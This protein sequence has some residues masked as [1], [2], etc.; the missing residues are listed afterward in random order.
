MYLQDINDV[1]K[2]VKR[3]WK[4]AR[5][6]L[7]SALLLRSAHPSANNLTELV[8]DIPQIRLESNEHDQL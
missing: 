4:A 3:K 2:A 8:A 1:K 7:R 5:N 6:V